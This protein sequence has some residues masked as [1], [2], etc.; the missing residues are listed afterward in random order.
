M[1]TS[2]LCAALLLTFH[3]A[4]ALSGILPGNYAGR[5]EWRDDAGHSGFYAV[6]TNV[7][8]SR[9][10]S[11]YQFS[12]GEERFNLKLTPDGEVFFKTLSDDGEQGLMYCLDVQCHMTSRQG[13]FEE[14]LSFVDD[15]LYKIGSKK[16][17]DGRT[18]VWQESLSRSN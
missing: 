17:N 18:I 4:I 15:H 5:G 16:T 1:R 8:A 11:T 3:S 7:L 14:T 6:E 10:E 12:S 13:L 9:L 2:V